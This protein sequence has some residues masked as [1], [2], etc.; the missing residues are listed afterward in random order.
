MKNYSVCSSSIGDEE[1]SF[2]DE[3]VNSFAYRN[4]IKRLAS[5][6]KATQQNAK[7]DECHILDEPLID[8]EEPSQSHNGFKTKFNA[9]SNHPYLTPTMIITHVD[10]L[11]NEVVEDLKLLRP[12]TIV[13]PSQYFAD[14]NRDGTETHHIGQEDENASGPEGELVRY[15]PDQTQQLPLA[16]EIYT[17]PKQSTTLPS[18]PYA[19]EEVLEDSIDEGSRTLNRDMDS[20]YWRDYPYTITFP[21]EEV[22]DKAV[23]LFDFAK[24]SEDELPLNE[25]Q[26]I[27]VCS[28]QSQGWVMAEDPR[29]GE[30]GYVPENFVRLLPDVEGGWSTLKREQPAKLSSPFSPSN[31]GT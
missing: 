4:F 31:P 8:L 16:S 27:W 11:S 15:P 22:H 30:L 2:D 18:R 12:T 5:K 17:S 21:D 29:T 7:P 26:I 1:F 3:I 25:G 14:F 9:V 19:Q 13:S 10:S 24:E 6:N 28:Q 20:R 23:A